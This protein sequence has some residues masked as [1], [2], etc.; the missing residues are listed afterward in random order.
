MDEETM[1]AEK[2]KSKTKEKPSEDQNAQ[3]DRELADTFP[4]SDPLSTTRPG[5]NVGSPNHKA[6]KTK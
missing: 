6:A 3:L 2:V 5:A 1:M 4:A